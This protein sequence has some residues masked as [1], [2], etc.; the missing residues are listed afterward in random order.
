MDF[1][2][3]GGKEGFCKFKIGIPSIYQGQQSL[4]D[5]FGGKGG[6]Y[7]FMQHKEKINYTMQEMQERK[8]P[9]KYHS[10]G[11]QKQKK[12]KEDKNEREEFCRS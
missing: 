6:K 5:S 12:K 1:S 11:K 7:N 3:S 2:F 9:M 4:E 10:A 8:N